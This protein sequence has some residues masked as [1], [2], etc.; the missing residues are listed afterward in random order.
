MTG[1]QPLNPGGHPSQKRLLTGNG[2]PQ[3]P[4]AKPRGARQK[5]T[6]DSWKMIVLVVHNGSFHRLSLSWS[7]NHVQW[8]HLHFI[9]KCHPKM[10]H[11]NCSSETF[12]QFL[13]AWG[14][15]GCWWLTAG[16]VFQRFL[17]RAARCPFRGPS[18]LGAV[19]SIKS[20][21]TEAGWSQIFTNVIYPLVI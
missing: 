21:M 13:A 3:F 7:C 20:A 17:Q 16:Q 12:A 11:N 4:E 19:N 1:W 8:Q 9:F 2:I 5:W 15:N 18:S 10:Q 14:H 6:P